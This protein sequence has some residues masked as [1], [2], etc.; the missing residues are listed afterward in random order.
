VTLPLV[1][2]ICPTYNRPP[3]H[4]FLIEEAIES[5]LRQDYPNKELIVLNDC[6]GQELVCDAPGV[7]VCNVDTRFP[8]LGDKCNYAVAM[9]EGDLVAPWDDDDISLPWR[10][11][12]SVEQMGSADYFNP[13]AYWYLPRTGLVHDHSM[14]Y[15]HNASVFRRSAFEAVGGYRSISSGYDRDIDAALTHGNFK[16]VDL[17]NKDL[18]PLAIEVWFYLYRWGVSPGHVSSL[19]SDVGRYDLIGEASVMEASYYLEPR[20]QEDYETLVQRKIEQVHSEFRQENV[21]LTS[22]NESSL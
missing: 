5:F 15:A 6:P 10:L 20:W 7:R 11:S 2:C 19:S 16:T 4:Q 17:R 9:S 1:S 14:G 22:G 13:R 18:L 21:G 3:S 12:L 8:T